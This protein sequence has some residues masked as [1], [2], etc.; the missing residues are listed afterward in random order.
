M[1]L[2]LGLFFV[3]LTDDLNLASVAGALAPGR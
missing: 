1:L 2:H 3:R